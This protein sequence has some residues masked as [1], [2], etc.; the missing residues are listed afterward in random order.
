MTD[1]RTWQIQENDRYENITDTR[2]LQIQEH[3]RYNNI[4]YERIW[5]IQ[6][7]DRYK[8]N[9]NC[10]ELYVGPRKITLYEKNGNFGYISDS[11]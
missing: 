10:L 2:T 1:K 6:E 5:T 9:R 4:T 7:H 11:F 8:N 3:D